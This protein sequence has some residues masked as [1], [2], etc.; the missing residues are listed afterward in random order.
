[1]PETAVRVDPAL[2]FRFR[3]TLD[4]LALSAGFTDCQGLQAETEVLEYAEGGLNT[5]LHRFPTRTKHASITLRRGVVGLELW[6]WYEEL[7]NGLVRRR[8]GAIAVHDPAGE[9]VVAEWRFRGAFPCKWVGPDLAAGTSAI[10]V[11]AVELCH[12]GLTRSR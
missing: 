2:A 10:A 7:V 4:D 6:T 9:R 5:N 12:E 1:M 11:E 8:N 3:V